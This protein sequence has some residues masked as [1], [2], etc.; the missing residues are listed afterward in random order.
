[1]FHYRNPGGLD[2]SAVRAVRAYD[3]WPGCAPACLRSATVTKACREGKE[4][5]GCKDH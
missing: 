3:T 4:H 2:L 5:K 1:V